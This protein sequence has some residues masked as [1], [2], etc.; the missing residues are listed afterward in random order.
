ME[1]VPPSEIRSK[2]QRYILNNIQ[3]GIIPNIT[4][5]VKIEKYFMNVRKFKKI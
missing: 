3:T 4:C 5:S 1:N 2:Q